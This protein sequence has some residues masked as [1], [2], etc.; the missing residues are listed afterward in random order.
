M[1]KGLHFYKAL[2]PIAQDNYPETL[3]KIILINIP[4]IGRGLWSIVQHWIDPKTKTKMIFLGPDY[5]KILFENVA[6][7]NIPEDMGGTCHCPGGCLGKPSVKSASVVSAFHEE[8]QCVQGREY[9]RWYFQADKELEFTIKFTPS[10]SKSLKDSKNN[11]KTKT[12][13]NPKEGVV[14]QTISS[15]AIAPHETVS[16]YYQVTSPGL[17][18]A[19]WENKK[20]WFRANLSYYLGVE[21]PPDGDDAQPTQPAF[22]SSIQPKKKISN[23]NNNNNNNDFRTAP[24]NKNSKMTTNNRN[25]RHETKISKKDFRTSSSYSDFERSASSSGDEGGGRKSQASQIQAKPRKR[26]SRDK[27]K[28]KKTTLQIS[29]EQTTM[30][31]DQLDGSGFP[32]SKYW[33]KNYRPSPHSINSPYPFS[34]SFDESSSDEDRDLFIGDKNRR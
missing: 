18:I 12:S 6:P 3:N 34:P 9:I 19:T 20:G 11:K 1:Y 14:T 25:K 17:L 24:N 29:T 26:H 10:N 15:R 2:A 28:N 31:E 5:H 30:G 16:D 7:E 27:K 21:V 23:H 13:K 33:K 8:I 4:A 22:T 32:I